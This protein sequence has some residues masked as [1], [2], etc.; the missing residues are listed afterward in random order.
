MRSAL[1]RARLRWLVIEPWAYWLCLSVVLI[2][3]MFVFLY[4]TIDPEWRARC[5][6][7]VLQILGLGTTVLGI[8]QTRKLFGKPSIFRV[9]KRWIERWPKRDATAH[10]GAGAAAI[11]GC[12][13]ILSVGRAAAPP[14]ASLEQ[15]VQR[16][17]EWL[18]LLEQRDNAIEQQLA[19][20]KANRVQT[21]E[22]ERKARMAGDAQLGERLEL[23]ARE[24]Y[25]YR[26]WA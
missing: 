20:E 26:L 5:A 13:A 14:G 2:S 23:S 16:L 15:R 4:P 22:E 19:T 1:L 17:E 3:G 8:Q 10:L 11:T 24:G 25:D 21:E 12:S 9:I 18:P 7:T 6:G